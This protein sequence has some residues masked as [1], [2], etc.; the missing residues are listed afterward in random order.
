MTYE[1]PDFIVL[2][3]DMCNVASSHF[4]TVC[5]LKISVLVSAI[6]RTSM[7]GHNLYVTSVCN[8][9]GVGMC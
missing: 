6:K 4:L 7:E 3:L 5:T 2:S 8:C 1:G 9:W